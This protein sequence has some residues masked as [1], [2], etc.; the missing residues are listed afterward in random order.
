MIKFLRRELLDKKTEE[1]IL[2]I[3]NSDRNVSPMKIYI[4]FLFKELELTSDPILLKEL[5]E[6]K[7]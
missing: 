2:K 3:F 7:K 4:S 5:D 1:E 6:I